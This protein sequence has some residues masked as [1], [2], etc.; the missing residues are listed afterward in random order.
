MLSSTKRR[1]SGFCNCCAQRFGATGVSRREFLAGAASAAAVSVSSASTVFAQA[2]PHRI[3]VHH[4]IVPPSWLNAMDII[5]RTNPPLAH[6]SVQKAIDDM[7]KGGVATS[8]TS[9]T[10]PQVAT[11][12]TPIAVKIAREFERVFQEARVQITR[13]G[14]ALSRCCRCLISTRV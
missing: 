9:P 4:H 6:W 10:A 8:I 12:G 3:D 13:A 14:S 7:D 5:G 1:L 2:A 11:L